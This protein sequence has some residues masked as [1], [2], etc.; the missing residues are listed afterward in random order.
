MRIN[1]LSLRNYRG[2]GHSSVRFRPRGLTVVVGPNES[3][4]SSLAQAL[5]LA[6]EY[7]DSSGKAAIKDIRPVNSDVGTEIEMD[8]ETGDYSFVYT[9]QF[10]KDR[11]TKLVIKSPKAETLV[12][13]DAHD[14]VL[15][16]F[17]ATIDMQLWR[18][19]SILQGESFEVPD[20]AS[21]TGLL[22]ALDRAAGGAGS[23]SIHEDLYTR[24]RTEYEKYYTD[25]GTERK[26]LIDAKVEESDC[27]ELV[28][29]LEQKL[30]KLEQDAESVSRLQREL[31]RSSAREKVLEDD[32]SKNRTL[33]ATIREVESQ[34]QALT[35]KCEVAEVA[36]KEAT[37]IHS[38]RLSQIA[39]LDAAESSCSQSEE[40]SEPLE[41]R[42]IFAD[43]AHK[44]AQTAEMDAQREYLKFERLRKLRQA[45]SDHIKL[46]RELGL[47][48]ARR[49]R[50]VQARQRK[51]Q[52]EETISSIL[53]SAELL[54]KIE[55][56]EVELVRANA[57]LETGSP[58]V[59][60]G[61]LSRTTIRINEEIVELTSGQKL[62]RTVTSSTSIVVP[63]QVEVVVIPGGNT[64]DLQANADRARDELHSLCKSVGV[65]NPSEA[66]EALQRRIDAQ[67]V[68][69]EANNIETADLHTFTSFERMEE[70]F[71]AWQQKVSQYER[72]R[73][74][75]FPLPTSQR[76]AIELLE[77]ANLATENA[78]TEWDS[79][80]NEL[81]TARESRD[82]ANSSLRDLRVRL[83]AEKSEVLVLKEKLGLS[84]ESLSDA[85]LAARV[86]EC[87]SNLAKLRTE[88]D[89]TRS[90]LES[91]APD[92]ARTL[93]ATAAD[94]LKT[95]RD[96][97][98]AGHAE[99][100]KVQE[101]LKM[102]GEEGYFGALE[103]A[104]SRLLHLRT[105]NA[106]LFRKATATKL[107]FETIK[108]ERDKAH[109]TLV[110]P[111]KNQID[112]LGRIML[113]PTFEVEI[114][115]GLQLTSRTFNGV[116]IPFDGLS[117]GMKEQLAMIVR[118]A[119]ARLIDGAAGTPI[120]IDDALGNT[121]PERL[122]LMGAVIA[123]V[124]KSSQIVI[125]TCDPERYS[126]VGDATI[127]RLPQDLTS[128]ETIGSS[129]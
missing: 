129:A 106:G 47:L 50:I 86:G 60:V 97:R 117:G 111:L 59:S 107:L 121:D 55:S 95:A 12:G 49:E 48:S 52:A 20:L 69:A 8:V 45:D 71:A 90:Q 63:G 19:L 120:I 11:Q 39:A 22:K 87:D 2:V 68:M 118:L 53:L 122:R 67:S 108:S 29:N 36:L 89:Q 101:R 78:R 104:R 40:R 32:V 62:E 123:S 102:L 94:S 28:T 61:G 38:E 5:W 58:S 128:A 30:A 41:T 9:K 56:A 57:S 3:G 16:I 109:R 81:D 7:P 103:T 74:A 116:T 54:R 25:R 14:R 99:V 17:D 119:C 4:K 26:D 66:R 77:A 23:D 70:T 6:L 93:E 72:S 65:L 51:H 100:V 33:L 96:Q 114:S 82:E 27:E 18:A 80:R 127:V 113:G 31:L 13:R 43:Q 115:E 75:E 79:R 35:H 42:A 21:L 46:V 91:M 105:R 15:A 92:T 125:L 10:N 64:A 76:E 34:L 124:G 83:E 1:R 88:R 85:Q 24:I 112:Q 110:A 126:N 84:R 44:A 37:R 98:I 73:S